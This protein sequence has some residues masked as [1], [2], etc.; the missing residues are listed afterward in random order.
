MEH[1]REQAPD[2]D[3]GSPTAS[4][5]R[6]RLRD[7]MAMVF[8]AAIALAL[9]VFCDS[10]A[11]P[12]YTFHEP[13]FAIYVAVLSTAAIAAKVG[14]KRRRPFWSGV[15]IFGGLY[16]VTGLHLGWGVNDYQSSASLL[17]RCQIALP[18]G[19]LCGMA[20]QW[21]VIPSSSTTEHGG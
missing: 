6:L 5:F 12:G 3:R 4:R 15:T 20:A 16:L 8:F 18:L 2:A 19:I 14:R 21:F 17:F 9:Y 7:A 1:E 10:P 11:R 13:A